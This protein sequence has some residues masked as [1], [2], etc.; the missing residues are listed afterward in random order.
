M[1]IYVDESFGLVNHHSTIGNRADDGVILPNR[2]TTTA[3]EVE[4]ANADWALDLDVDLA[5]WAGHRGPQ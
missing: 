3:S 2:P 5:V 1:S 4:A